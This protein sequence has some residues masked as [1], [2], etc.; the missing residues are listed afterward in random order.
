MWIWKRGDSIVIRMMTDEDG[1]YYASLF[2]YDR[3]GVLG[4]FVL[5][6]FL[7]LAALGGKK[8][9]GPWRGFSLPWPA[10]GSFCFPD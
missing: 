4:I 3:G 7:L 5:I 9:S 2:N 1:S 6:F 10:S 8:G